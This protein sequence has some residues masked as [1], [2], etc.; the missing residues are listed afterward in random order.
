M[1]Q[2]ATDDEIR[3]LFDD[4]LAHPEFRPAFEFGLSLLATIYV[5]DVRASGISDPLGHTVPLAVVL[6]DL[7]RH[8]GLP[9]PA[10]AGTWL[11]ARAMPPDP[12]A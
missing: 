6:A 4:F 2:T 8:V 11:A 12:V 3:N 9:A 10:G 1:H 5:E 7:A